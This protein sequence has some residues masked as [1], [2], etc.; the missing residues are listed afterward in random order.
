[1]ADDL[2][3]QERAWAAKG[4]PKLHIG[5]QQ[6]HLDRPPIPSMLLFQQK[7]ENFKRDKYLKCNVTWKNT[8]QKLSYN[9]IIFLPSTKRDFTLELFL[10]D[11]KT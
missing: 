9:E 5:R 1:M 11:S 10:K 3:I 4:F 2:G 6:S 8:F 7:K